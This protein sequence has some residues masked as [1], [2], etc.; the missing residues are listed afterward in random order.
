MMANKASL[1]LHKEGIEHI[2][3]H[4]HIT[5]KEYTQNVNAKYGQNF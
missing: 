3:D 4:G 2:E 1:S 5:L